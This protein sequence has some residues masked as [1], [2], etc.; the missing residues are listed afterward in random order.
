MYVSINKESFNQKNA[1]V[2]AFI[3]HLDII[4]SMPTPAQT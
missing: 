4:Q 2:Q 3:C 1:F